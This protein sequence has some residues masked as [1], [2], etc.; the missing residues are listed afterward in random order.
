MLSFPLRT[1]SGWFLSSWNFQLQRLSD[2]LHYAWHFISRNCLLGDSAVL[3]IV[4]AWFPHWIAPFATLKSSLVVSLTFLGPCGGRTHSTVPN[5]VLS[6][7]KSIGLWIAY[8]WDVRWGSSSF[9]LPSL[10]SSCDLSCGLIGSNLGCH[11]ANW[12][13]DPACSGYWCRL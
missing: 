2:D 3:M 5:S 7:L 13:R 4:Q 10:I 12:F 8:S 9:P 11:S 1:L 6:L